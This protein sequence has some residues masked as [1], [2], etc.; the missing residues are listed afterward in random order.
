MA[1]DDLRHPKGTASRAFL[2]FLRLGEI[3]SGSIV[4]GILGREF[5]LLSLADIID[6]DARLVFAAVIAALAIVD[7]LVFIVPYP[8][9]F[10]SFPLDIF[11]FAAWLAVF[12]V[13]ETV[14]YLIPPGPCLVVGWGGWC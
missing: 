2:V 5:Y 7:A 8:Y 13:L 14:G 4:L 9:A 12:C 3:V 10:W 1:S 6:P 11:F